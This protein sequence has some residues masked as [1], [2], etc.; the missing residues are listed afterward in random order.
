MVLTVSSFIKAGRPE[1]GLSLKSPASN[2]SNYLLHSLSKTVPSPKTFT[3]FLHA[4]VA[5]LVG[6]RTKYNVVKELYQ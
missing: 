4:S 1:R 3:K 6:I 5:F 2:F